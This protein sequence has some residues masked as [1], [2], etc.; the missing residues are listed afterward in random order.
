MTK[1]VEDVVAVKSMH[2]Q[3]SC[4][5]SYVKSTD[6]YEQLQVSMVRPLYLLF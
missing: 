2:A 3:L 5:A 4:I 1:K 6:E